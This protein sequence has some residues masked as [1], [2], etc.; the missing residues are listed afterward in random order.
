MC[1]EEKLIASINITWSLFVV[2]GFSKFG[3]VYYWFYVIDK[4]SWLGEVTQKVSVIVP[5]FCGCYVEAIII[6]NW[7]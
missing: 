1:A 2:S 3:E 7:Y 5:V 6:N 4:L